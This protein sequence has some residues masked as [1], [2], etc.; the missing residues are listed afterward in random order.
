MEFAE[1]ELTED[2]I[3]EFVSSLPATLETLALIDIPKFDNEHILALPSRLK[4]LELDFSETA[5]DFPLEGD[6]LTFP[7]E[8]TGLVISKLPKRHLGPFPSTLT[9]LRHGTTPEMEEISEW[10]EFFDLLPSGLLHLRAVP[11]SSEMRTRQEFRGPINLPKNLLTLDT[12]CREYFN[13]TIHCIPST[14]TKL[15]AWCL[16]YET[17]P[18]EADWAVSAQFHFPERQLLLLAKFHPVCSFLRLLDVPS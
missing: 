5:P 14:V 15:K 18:N 7:P 1:H 17:H 2:Q 16:T 4:R 12:P 9:S 6:L 3:S 11:H 13:E 8:L 10:P